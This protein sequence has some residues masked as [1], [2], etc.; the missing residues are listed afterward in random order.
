MY[1]ILVLIIS[2]HIGNY[3]A[4]PCVYIHCKESMKSVVELF[5]ET[6]SSIILIWY[7]S[8]FS[9]PSNTIPFPQIQ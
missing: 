1:K 7:Q 3:V 8:C 9:P 5:I 4:T 2:K 6:V